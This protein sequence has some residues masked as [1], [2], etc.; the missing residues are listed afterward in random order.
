VLGGGCGT[1]AGV[2]QVII[3]KDLERRGRRH[4]ATSTTPTAAAARRRRLVGATHA[5]TDTQDNTHTEG[6]K[7]AKGLRSD[8]AIGG[9]KHGQLQGVSGCVGYPEVAVLVGLLVVLV[10]PCLPASPPKAAREEAGRAEGGGPCSGLGTTGFSAT[11][12][13]HTQTRQLSLS[14]GRHDAC[15]T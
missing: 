9:L 10:P 8:A 12:K 5:A 3:H 4:I 11:Q 2:A 7:G 15:D 6:E 13:T 1:S 14:R